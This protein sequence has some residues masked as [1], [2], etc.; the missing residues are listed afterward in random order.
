MHV[1]TISNLTSTAYV[2]IRWA[3]RWVIGIVVACDIVRP[4]MNSFSFT[5]DQNKKKHSFQILVSLCRMRFNLGICTAFVKDEA[6]SH[7][8]CNTK[9]EC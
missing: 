5:V 9:H 1:S 3:G 4:S 8:F 2:I 7:S 6:A